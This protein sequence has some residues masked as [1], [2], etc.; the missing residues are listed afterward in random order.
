MKIRMQAKWQMHVIG[1]PFSFTVISDGEDSDHEAL[2]AVLKSKLEAIDKDD[3]GAVPQGLPRKKSNILSK[4]KILWRGASDK[5][6][7]YQG[8]IGNFQND[9]F[10]THPFV[11]DP[12]ETVCNL[13]Q[14]PYI[15]IG[16]LSRLRM[17]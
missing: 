11:G 4:K 1:H 13:G 14:G 16:S 15:Y 10:I 7:E 5:D 12:F 6:R 9:F 3:D 2:D 17:N 8:T